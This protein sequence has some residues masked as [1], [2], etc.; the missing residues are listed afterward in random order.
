MADSLVSFFA[1]DA[2]AAYLFRQDAASYFLLSKSRNA[3]FG[4]GRRLTD[5]SFG[6]EFIEAMRAAYRMACEAPQLIPPPYQIDLASSR[7]SAVRGKWVASTA[8][9]ESMA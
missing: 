5:H 4:S 2:F 7:V 8:P 3:S 6:P 9:Q 1:V